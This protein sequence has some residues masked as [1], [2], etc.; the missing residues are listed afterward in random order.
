MGSYLAD[1]NLLLRLADSG[2]DQHAIATR[3][4][5]MQCRGL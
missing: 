1:T 5:G 3:A 4:F 2:S